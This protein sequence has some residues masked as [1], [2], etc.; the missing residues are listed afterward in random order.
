[1]KSWKTS[2]AGVSTVLGGIAAL[3]A[4]VAKGNYDGAGISAAIAAITS[5]FGLMFARDNK[6]S[7]E[8]VGIR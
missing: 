3:A 6:V 7:S 5:G 4:M 2:L 8:D 1:M